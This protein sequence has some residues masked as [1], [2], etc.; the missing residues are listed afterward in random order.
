ME[1]WNIPL[2]MTTKCVE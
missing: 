2:G 1:S